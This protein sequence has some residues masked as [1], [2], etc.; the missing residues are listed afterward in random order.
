MMPDR[1]VRL[2]TGIEGRGRLSA[3]DRIEP[4]GNVEIATQLFTELELS[5]FRDKPVRLSALRA[6]LSARPRRPNGRGCRPAPP[7]TGLAGTLGN[8]VGSSP[9]MQKVFSQSAS[10]HSRS[11]S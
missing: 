8:M 5:W 2:V 11:A 1:R 7:A 6:D 4:F 3:R 9:E 10:A